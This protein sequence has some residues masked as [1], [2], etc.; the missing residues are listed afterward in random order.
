[1]VIMYG[2]DRVPG[3][4][5]PPG[6]SLPQLHTLTATGATAETRTINA[7]GDAAAHGVEIAEVTIAAYGISEHK[8]VTAPVEWHG[9]IEALSVVT[10]YGPNY[11]RRV[12]DTLDSLSHHARNGY[13]E[14]AA[15]DLAYCERIAGTSP[16]TES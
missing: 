3:P 14:L 12:V 9:R 15:A 5:T 11:Q 7:M 6:R 4:A 8:T 1:M 2:I 16:T 13:L 10:Q